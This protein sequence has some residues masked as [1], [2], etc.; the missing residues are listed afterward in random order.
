MKFGWRGG[1]GLGESCVQL[2]RSGRGVGHL[3]TWGLRVHDKVCCI[4]VVVVVVLL[5]LLGNTL[6]GKDM[7]NFSLLGDPM[8]TSSGCR[9]K[10]VLCWFCN[11]VYICLSLVY[12]EPTTII[13]WGKNIALELE[14]L[15]EAREV[16]EWCLE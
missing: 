8:W 10:Y 1:G 11:Q 12:A 4:V 9:C 5:L 13:A 15:V 14:A 2:S 6:W 3:M 16:V 7:S